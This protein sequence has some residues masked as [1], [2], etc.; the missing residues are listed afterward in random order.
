MGSLSMPSTPF[1][2]RPSS[3][4]PSAMAASS[5]IL[6]TRGLESPEGLMW[7]SKRE[8]FLDY[9]GHLV[10]RSMLE[11]AGRDALGSAA[12]FYDRRIFDVPEPR[13][14]RIPT[15]SDTDKARKP[16]EITLSRRTSPASSSTAS[17]R[18]TTAVNTPTTEYKTLL[19]DWVHVDKKREPK[20]RCLLHRL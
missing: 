19:D 1:P 17:S 15:W 6:E 5:R 14:S 7:A 4:S 8:H 10:S 9:R 18:L 20:A 13:P 11:K 16:E 12:R 2:S 3:P